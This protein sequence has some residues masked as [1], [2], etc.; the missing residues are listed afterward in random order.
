MASNQEN[1]KNMYVADKLTLISPKQLDDF[2]TKRY[3][4]G[5]LPQVSNSL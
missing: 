5:H 3:N 1:F 2:Y 4:E